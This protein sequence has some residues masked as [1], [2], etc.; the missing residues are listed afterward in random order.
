MTN[1][2]LTEAWLAAG[3]LE[4][5]VRS[6]RI[7]GTGAHHRRSTLAA[8]PELCRRSA[9]VMGDMAAGAGYRRAGS[10]APSAIPSEQTRWRRYCRRHWERRD[11]RETES[12][13]P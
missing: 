2:A 10:A 9:F 3:G 6:L 12:R 4:P 7:P 5:V 13:S 11:R 8:R 1:L